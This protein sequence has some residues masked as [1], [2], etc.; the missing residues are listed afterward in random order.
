MFLTG[1]KRNLKEKQKR[2]QWKVDSD[3]VARNNIENA[4]DDLFISI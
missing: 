2:E 3:S 4:R 1:I